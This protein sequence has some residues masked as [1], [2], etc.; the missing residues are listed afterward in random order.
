MASALVRALLRKTPR[1]AEVTV[2]APGFRTPRID[3]HRCSASITTIDAPRLQVSHQGVRDLAGHP[4]LHL[5]PPGVGSTSRASLDRPV[6]WPFS[7]GI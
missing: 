5:R 4:L 3:M 1:T 7:F 6:I 2:L